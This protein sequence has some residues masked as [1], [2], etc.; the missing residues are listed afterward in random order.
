MGDQNIMAKLPLA[1]GNLG[2]QFTAAILLPAAFFLSVF[3]PG[4]TEPNATICPHYLGLVSLAVGLLV[5]RIGLAR[6]SRKGKEVRRRG[7]A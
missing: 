4:R 1:A 7:M 6:G 2:T 5:L 3:S